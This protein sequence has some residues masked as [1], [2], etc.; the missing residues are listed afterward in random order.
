VIVPAISKAMVLGELEPIRFELFA[1]SKPGTTPV[2]PKLANQLPQQ[3]L[4]P[5]LRP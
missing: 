2:C 3:L 1:L 5:K 4:S